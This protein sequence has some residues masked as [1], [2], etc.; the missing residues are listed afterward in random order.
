MARGSDPR[1]P[2]AVYPQA[3]KSRR[4]GNRL[5]LFFHTTVAGVF[6]AESERWDRW[7][8]DIWIR[9]MTPG[10][11]WK[12]AFGRLF[13]IF[14]GGLHC[15]ELHIVPLGGALFGASATGLLDRI[16]WGERAVAIL[17]DRLIWI[18]SARGERTRVHYG[19]LDVE[20]LG[21]IYEGLLE[22][23]PGI[24]T[25]SLVRIRRGKME[26]VVAA[27]RPARRHSTRPVLFAQRDRPQGLGFVL[28]A[29]RI[30]SLSGAGDLGPQDRR[31]QSS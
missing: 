3:G 21:S 16:D 1:L 22:Q 5:Q 15:S 17:L 27:K 2:A 7:Y 23:E 4:G 19:S 30:R 12:V 11:C 25:E 14:R 10:G 26:A 20:D 9:G 18:V 29:A 6:V 31:S 13:E 28:H 8:E 24:A